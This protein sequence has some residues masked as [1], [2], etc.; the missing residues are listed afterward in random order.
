M[1]KH[2]LILFFLTLHFFTQGQNII[3]NPDFELYS[4]CPTSQGEVYKANSW[5]SSVYSPD[6]YNCEF[7]TL[8]DFPTNSLAFSGT[9]LIGF[10]SYGDLNGS[11]EAIGQHLPQSL[12]PNTTYSISFSAKRPSQGFF[13]INNCGG[14]AVYGFKDSIPIDTIFIHASQLSNA[15]LL[16]S[17]SAIQDSNW[18]THSINFNVTDTINYIV[19]T[20]EKV[21]MCAAYIFMDSASLISL[22]PSLVNEIDYTSQIGIYP[23]P[24]TGQFTLLLPP[25]NTKITITN[26]LGQ[27]LTTLDSKLGAVNLNL[28]DDG[29]YFVSVKTKH[30][31]STR[32]LIVK[33]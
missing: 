9:G 14:I 16:G 29:I 10:A 31:I 33:R 28:D 20:T 25:E 11:G 15:I 22:T 26:I 3:L 27:A 19:F 2:T 13:S 5:F 32:K 6:Y 23:N 18:T 1:K 12:L 30:G 17:S 24:T 21:P 7:T 8:S 4:T